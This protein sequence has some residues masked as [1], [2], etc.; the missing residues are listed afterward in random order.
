VQALAGLRAAQVL[1]G[2]GGRSQ[3]PGAR[4]FIGLKEA[5]DGEGLRVIF[6]VDLAKPGKGVF[7]EIRAASSSPSS[8]RSIARLPAVTKV[9]LSSS[10]RVRRHHARLSSSSWRASPGRP[11]SRS[12]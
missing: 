2:G 6:A 9:R 4:P 5:G 7:V 11:I 1:D 12:A 3:D 10:P 8:R